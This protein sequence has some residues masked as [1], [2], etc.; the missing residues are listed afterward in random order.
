MGYDLVRLAERFL[1]FPRQVM[2]SSSRINR[3]MKK[4]ISFEK[5]ATARNDKTSGLR[6][7]E[8]S[9]TTVRE[10]E[11]SPINIDVKFTLEQATKAQKI[12][13]V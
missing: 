7:L 12:V 5:S 2:P 13:E 1:T 11:I 3:S 6:R 9:E 4:S 10:P 8:S